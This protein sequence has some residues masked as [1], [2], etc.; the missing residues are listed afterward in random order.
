MVFVRKRYIVLHV[1]R[2]LICA[3]ASQY[4]KF[5]GSE[6]WCSL[7]YPFLVPFFE[8]EYFRS[9]TLVTSA[10]GKAKAVMIIDTHN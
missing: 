3:F 6:D 8:R 7:S 1:D 9:L 5:V 10:L 2:V 4:A